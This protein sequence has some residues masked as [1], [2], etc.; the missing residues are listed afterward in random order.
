MSRQILCLKCGDGAKLHP[1]DAK[2]GCTFRRC[3]LSLN[4]EPAADHGA[5]VISSGNS[6]FT[7][8]PAYHCD[9]C[10]EVISGQI[11]VAV[12]IIPP[13][14]EMRPWEHEYGRVM[15]DEEVATYRRLAV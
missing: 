9:I 3:Y 14:R 12:C 4:R 6:V 15:T 2:M 1:E 8:M 10:N 13:E 7:H 11:A 5:T